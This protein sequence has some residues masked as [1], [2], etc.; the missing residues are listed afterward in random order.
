MQAIIA[1]LLVGPLAQAEEATV[2]YPGDDASMAVTRVSAT[3]ELDAESIKPV[4]LSDITVGGSPVLYGPGEAASCGGVASTMSALRG[5]VKRAESGV[6]YMEF[7]QAKAHLKTAVNALACLNEPVHPETGSRLHYLQGILLHADG[8]NDSA[9][10]AYKKAHHYSPGLTWDDY[11]PPDSVELFDAAAAAVK[12][13]VNLTLAEIPAPAAGA[14]W[15]DGRSV[16]SQSGILSLVEGEHLI[17]VVGNEAIT[18]SLTL[19]PH[20]ASGESSKEEP[21]L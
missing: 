15:V 7:D 10:A 18:V 5:A 16:T 2:I 17:Q 8:D 1:L 4:T 9:L 13:S 19:S 6:A 3:T 14:L 21:G 11:F 20:E 12:S